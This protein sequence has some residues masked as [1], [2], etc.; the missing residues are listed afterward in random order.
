MHQTGA[1]L[2]INYLR[3][4]A[5]RLSLKEL[6]E[7]G[8]SLEQEGNYKE[9]G[10]SYT[11]AIRRA[12]TYPVAY[13]RLMILFRKQKK[14]EKEVELISKAIESYQQEMAEDRRQWQKDNTTSADISLKL[15]KSMGLINEQ[16]LPVYE[17]PPVATWRKRLEVA[18]KKLALQSNKP[19]KSSVKKK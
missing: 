15:A 3:E 13:N 2:L 14:Y 7:K 6:I 12:P 11:A 4:M 10:K 18:R 16:G 1:R 19:Q 8:L 17:D 9:A 5:A